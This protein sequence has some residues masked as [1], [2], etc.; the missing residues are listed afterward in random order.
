M[1]SLLSENKFYSKAIISVPS[2]GIQEYLIR[3]CGQI[4][5]PVVNGLK[6]AGNLFVLALDFVSERM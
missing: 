1:L 5:H 4:I 6:A 3:I 2:Y